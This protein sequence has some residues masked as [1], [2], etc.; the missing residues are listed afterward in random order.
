MKV[1]PVTVIVLAIC[2]AIVLLA[3]PSARLTIDCEKI[4]KSHCNNDDD[5]TC[6]SSPCLGVVNKNYSVC[7]KIRQN[8]SGTIE[9]C[10]DTCSSRTIILFMQWRPLCLN[11]KCTNAYVNESFICITPDNCIKR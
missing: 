9:S 8:L 7:E 5:C 4:N 2:F 11:N 6:E 3:L 10:T 1:L